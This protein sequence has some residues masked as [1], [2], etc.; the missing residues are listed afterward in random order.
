MKI[1]KDDREWEITINIKNEGCIFLYYPANYHGC[2]HPE[3]KTNKRKEGY[4]TYEDCPIRS[5]GGIRK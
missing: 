3:H 2:K 4:C 1:I 5:K